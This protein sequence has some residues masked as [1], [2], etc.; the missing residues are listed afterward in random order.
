MTLD[1]LVGVA[2]S[3]VSMLAA[4]LEAAAQYGVCSG[5]AAASW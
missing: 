1:W 4:L 3:V 2:L 5:L